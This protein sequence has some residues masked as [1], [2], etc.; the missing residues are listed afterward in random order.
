VEINLESTGGD[1]GLQHFF[2]SKITKTCSFV[3]CRIS[4]QQ[5]KNSKAEIHFQ[6]PKKYCLGDV[7]SVRCHS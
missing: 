5:E 6:I 4:V 3:G 2:G 7:Q 1:K